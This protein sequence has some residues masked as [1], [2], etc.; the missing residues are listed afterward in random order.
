MSPLIRFT[1][2]SL[3]LIG[4][5]AAMSPQAQSVMKSFSQVRMSTHQGCFSISLRRITT[6]PN[7]AEA[8]RRLPSRRG[9]TT[10]QRTAWPAQ[11]R[12]ARGRPRPRRKNGLV[13]CQH[14][15]LA[16][17]PGSPQYWAPISERAAAYP[18]WGAR[19]PTPEHRDPGASACHP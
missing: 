9:F 13:Q 16:S 18:D 17:W 1:V 7:A 11:A 12:P 5:L 3:L 15:N 10:H 2:L 4:V 19:S 14:W 6:Q 8:R